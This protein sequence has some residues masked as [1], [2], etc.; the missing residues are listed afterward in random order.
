M[1]W[2]YVIIAIVLLAGCSD[3]SA[4]TVAPNV[5]AKQQAGA[6][7][8]MGLTFPQGTRF[9][10]Y[11][12]A[13]E[14]G[15]LPGPDDAVHLK[16]ELPASLLTDFLAQPPLTNARWTGGHSLMT[17]MLNWPQWK[18]SSVTKFRSEQF[19]LPHGQGLN[20]LID[21]DQADP[22]VVYLLWFET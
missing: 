20:V 9:L 15:G 10:F 12:R 1:Q 7:A 17:D 8:S 4:P 5:T 21:D 2:V 3:R 13:S 22:K 18:P 14:A 16:I 11:H 6:A 19:Q